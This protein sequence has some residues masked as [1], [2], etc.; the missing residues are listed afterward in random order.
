MPWY[1]LWCQLLMSC[2][3]IHTLLSDIIVMPSHS[4]NFVSINVM[5]IAHC[6]LRTLHTSPSTC[7]KST[8][9]SNVFHL[10]YMLLHVQ[11]CN[12]SV[13][14]ITRSIYVV[15]RACV[16]TA[17]RTADLSASVRCLRCC[18]S[19]NLGHAV[20][21]GFISGSDSTHFD[22]PSKVKLCL[23]KQ[24]IHVRVYLRAFN[25][26]LHIVF[27]FKFNVWTRRNPT[28]T[29]AGLWPKLMRML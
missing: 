23:F 3:H 5:H 8:C 7:T 14:V 27:V 18:Y 25:S 12:T 17:I 2:P 10:T 1:S 29:R 13:S 4:H 9:S 28:L 24:R 19:I 20:E 22:W 16:L 21:V 6:P 26:R 11:V 15:T